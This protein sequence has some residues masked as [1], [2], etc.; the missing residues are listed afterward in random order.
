MN[1]PVAR[2]VARP[3]PSGSPQ[4]IVEVRINARTPLRAA[5]TVNHPPRTSSH[6]RADPDSFTALAI[7]VAMAA[8]KPESWATCSGSSP[9]R[10]ATTPKRLMT[11]S[12]NGS[13]NRKMRYASPPDSSGPPRCRSMS[14]AS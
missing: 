3:A 6:Q 5:H 11:N 2:A 8:D 12:R 14:Q 4:A 1:I 7:V 13:S 9:L 10:S